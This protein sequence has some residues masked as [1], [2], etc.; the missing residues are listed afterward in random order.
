M[1]IIIPDIEGMCKFTVNN[2]CKIGSITKNIITFECEDYFFE[3]YGIEMTL[4]DPDDDGNH[5]V[6]RKY[7]NGKKKVLGWFAKVY[8][9][10]KKRQNIRRTRK[11]KQLN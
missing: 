5:Y 10:P 2:T 9:T 3:N 11:S 1:A 8:L 4:L 7:K 6:T